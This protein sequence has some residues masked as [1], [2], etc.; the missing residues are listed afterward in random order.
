MS[1]AAGIILYGH[2]TAPWLGKD[3]GFKPVMSLKAKIIHLK[4]INKGQ[5]VGYGRSF[6]ACGPTKVATIPLG[7]ADGL[8]RSL[9]NTWNVIVGGVKAKIIGKICM[10]QTMIDVTGVENVQLGDEVIVMGGSQN[11]EISAGEMAD[12][13]NTISYELLCGIAK[14]VPRVYLTP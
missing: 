2:K 1:C 7:Y 3:D 14:R 4:T 12:A 5:S 9:S 10:D 13:L 8:R 6:I 11:E